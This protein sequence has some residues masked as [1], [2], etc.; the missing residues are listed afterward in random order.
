MDD[1]YYKTWKIASRRSLLSI[2]QVKEVIKEISS[3]LRRPI[4]YETITTTTKGDI[5]RDK[6]IHELGQTGVFTKEVNKLVIED[7]AD[8]AVHSLKDLP[9]QLE[10][11]LV[12]AY[13]SRREKPNDIIVARNSDIPLP[14]ER[15]GK[16]KRIGTSSY[17]RTLFIKNINN[18]TNIVPIRGNIDT[19]L[20]KLD[21]NIVD[22]LVIGLPGY[23]RLLKY[24]KISSHPIR[25]LSLQKMTP[26]P[27]QG[28]I[29]VITR[30]NS[31]FYR[32]LKGIIDKV[33]LV[34]FEAERSFQSQLNLG[35]TMPV[36]GIA[37]PRKNR[38]LEF[39][40]KATDR[41]GMSSI[42][43]RIVGEMSNPQ[44]LG[45]QA[46]K[47]IIEWLETV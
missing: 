30:K 46:S 33:S 47:K 12:I 14:L 6:K 38:K 32:K 28:F 1:S 5:I 3:R 22:Y 16:E 13:V 4:K 10:E 15:I 35:C 36:G 18:N 9:S 37:I 29:A 8:I 11:E 44:K 27:G 7:K 43:I 25:V 39:I 20:K 19:R 24:K 26:T 42:L 2:I 45:I 41:R 21:E 23:R 31:V 17:R 40:A 34:A